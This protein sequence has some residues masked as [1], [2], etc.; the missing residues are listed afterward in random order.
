M[1]L[2][3]SRAD[4]ASRPWLRP[5]T[6]RYRPPPSCCSFPPA[7]DV[8]DTLRRTSFSLS[9]SWAALRRSSV[10]D[11]T[12]TSEA[13]R[14]ILVSVSLKS[15]RVPTSR[16]AWSTALR[17][18]CTSTWDT[19]SNEGMTVSSATGPNDR[20]RSAP[21]MALFHHVEHPP[22]RPGPVVRR[23][24]GEG[25]GQRRPGVYAAAPRR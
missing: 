18:S 15:Y 4:S 1:C 7:P 21:G 5:F 17:T 13:P 14:V 10:E 24:L 23:S 12:V 16:E 9:T 6:A 22:G 11:S 25:G 20:V 3:I 2:E 19:T 8:R